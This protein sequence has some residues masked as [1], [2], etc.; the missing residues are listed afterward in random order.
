M[1]SQGKL[2]NELKKLALIT[3][4]FAVWTGLIMLLKK[5]LL[6]QY[7]IHFNDMALA[8]IGAVLLAKVVL[9][10]E[11]IPMESWV[12]NHPAI[13]AVLL[14]TLMYVVGVLV[15]LTLEKAFEARHEFGGFVHA[16]TKVYQ[17]PEYPRVLFNTI[18]IGGALLGYNIFSVLSEHL[19]SKGLFRLF[20]G[21]HHEHREQAPRNEM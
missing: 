9:L 15:V 18:C 21:R 10:M 6:A 4:Y 1:I 19:G 8:L 7:G 11:P 20:F 17:H 2:V 5:L 14:R 12:P 3:L 16:L 13:V